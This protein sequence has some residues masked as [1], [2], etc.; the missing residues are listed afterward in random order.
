MASIHR[1][2]RSGERAVTRGCPSVLGVWDLRRFQTI[3]AQE[4]IF[5]MRLSH[6]IGRTSV[7]FDDH[8]LVSSGG[9]VPVLGLAESV[10]LRDLADEHLT[11]PTDPSP[12]S[13]HRR[14]P[15]RF[16]GCWWCAGS[17]TSTATSTSGQPGHPLRHLVVPRV[18][19]YRR[20]RDPQH[21]C[22]RRD[23]PRARGHRA[24]P[25]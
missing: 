17:P 14:S 18:V 15:S 19:H 13:L 2:E 7:G 23:P 1:C 24:G 20:S 10:G 4:G 25:L 9:P 6:T 22:G 5:K 11:V 8:N 16:P 3:N 12:P 21:R